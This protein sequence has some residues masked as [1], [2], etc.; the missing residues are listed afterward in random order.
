M[1]LREKKT[2]YIE[3]RKDTLYATKSISLICS[4]PLQHAAS[5]VIQYTILAW[6]PSV[7]QVTQVD[8]RRLPALGRNLR[9]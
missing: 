3:F 6:E 4:L 8:H 5:Q 9:F 2:I 7:A 1:A